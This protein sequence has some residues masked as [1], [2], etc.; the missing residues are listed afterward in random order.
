MN[1]LVLRVALA[2][3]C[4]SGV[5]CMGG[6]KLQNC[7]DPCWPQRYT[8]EARGSVQASFAPQVNNG[9]ILD[10]TVWNRHFEPGTDELNLS[11]RDKLDQIARR[12]PTPDGRVFMQTSRDVPYDSKDPD[13]YVNTVRELNERRKI[14][15]A[16]Y[17]NVQLA[18]RPAPLDI[19]VHDPSEP[20]LVGTAQRHIYAPVLRTFQTQTAAIAGAQQQPPPV[21]IQ[22]TPTGPAFAPTTAPLPGPSGTGTGR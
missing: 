1:G 13:K 18:G 2:G 5:G 17:M 4:A 21:L 8:N 22:P 20:G 7:Y 11:G 12:R 9:R 6:D 14:A 10:Q 16:K 15:I 19:V 3:L